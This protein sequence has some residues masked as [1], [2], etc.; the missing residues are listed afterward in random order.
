MKVTAPIFLVLILALSTAT[1]AQL[2]QSQETPSPESFPPDI[3]A[4]SSSPDVQKASKQ[5]TA[6]EAKSAIEE[7]LRTERRLPGENIN[8][9]VTEHAVVLSGSVPTE[10]DD[11]VARRIAESYAGERQVEDNLMIDSG[12][13][14]T[15]GKLETPP[16][17]TPPDNR[18]EPKT[19]PHSEDNLQ[20][21]TW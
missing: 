10:K 15:P 17:N 18:G 16:M 1:S 7:K 6:E 13:T 14:V 2:W 3:A 11:A 19:Q 5:L 8:V 4:P 9:H 21:L 20:L 12:A